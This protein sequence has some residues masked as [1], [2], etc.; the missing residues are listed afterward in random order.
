M[1]K[2]IEVNCLTI[3]ESVIEIGQVIHFFPKIGV[4]V[5]EL[6]LPLAISDRI[7][8]KGPTTDFEQTVESIQIDRKSIPRAEGGQSIGLK[9]L[10]PVKEKDK[11]YKKL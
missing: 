3:E 1:L 4:A 5:I 2:S 10:Q 11:V 6:K 9:L 7:T 8:V